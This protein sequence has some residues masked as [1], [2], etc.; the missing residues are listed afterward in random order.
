MILPVGRNLFRQILFLKGVSHMTELKLPTAVGQLIERLERAGFETYAVGGC[1]RDCLLSRTPE[2]WDLCT[3]ALPEQILALF[4]EYGPIPTG[5][6]H[7]TVTVPFDGTAYEITPFRTESGYADGR[8]PDRVLFGCTLEEDLARRDFTVNAM[9]YHPLRGLIDPF[10]GRQDLKA[11]LLRCVGDPIRRF[12]E[13][14]LRLLRGVRF[15]ALFGLT[16]EPATAAALHELAPTVVRAAPERLFPELL[17]LLCA[18]HAETALSE[19][20]D[21]LFAILPELAA[22]KDFPQNTPHHYL[23]IW[24]HTL[25]VLSASPPTPALRLAALLHDVAKPLCATVDAEGIS[26][27]KGH[28]VRGVEAADAILRRLRCSNTLRERVVS[29]VLL[30]DERTKPTLPAVRRLMARVPPSMLEELFALQRADVAGQAPDRRPEKLA[31]ISAVE[32]LSRQVLERELCCSLAQLAVSGDDLLALGSSRG[33]A[34]GTLLNRL[35]EAVMDEQVENDREA[36]LRQ[37]ALWLSE[38]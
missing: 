14:A 37:A 17:K 31:R 2:D 35:L 27:F 21:L 20:S 4:A 11:R 13:D 34:L 3:A 19:F 10:G 30:H 22:Q 9:A 24:R 36:L 29:L 33:P 38:S 16:V 18:P 25:A 32:A 26:H 23:D 28:P 15:L 8:H 5:L 1:V 6:S 12:G 7:G